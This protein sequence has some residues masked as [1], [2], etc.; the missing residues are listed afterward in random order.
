MS[1]RTRV[2]FDLGSIENLK[3]LIVDD[4]KTALKIAE[5]SFNKNGYF[6]VE[7]ASSGQEC[8]DKVK[9]EQYN[10]IVLDV[11]MEDMNGLDVLQN[12]RKDNNNMKTA[13][14]MA[15]STEDMPIVFD[16]LKKG[17]DEFIIKPITSNSLKNIWANVW[18]RKREQAILTK[19]DKKQQKVENTAKE[20]FSL[21]QK[22]DKLK[23]E[24]D[25]AVETPLK[26]IT[27]TITELL[28]KENNLDP[29]V[30]ETLSKIISTLHSS[31]LYRPVISEIL[32]DNNNNNNNNNNNEG[33]GSYT[34]DEQTKKWL[35]REI[36]Y[37][38]S[39][40][41]EKRRLSI[42][43]NTIL[44]KS[45]Q[46]DPSDES[47]FENIEFVELSEDIKE[48]IRTWD[49][50]VWKHDLDTL[51]SLILFMYE[52]LK[53]IQDFDLSVEQVK[54]FIYKCRTLYH[55][56]PYH[57]FRHAFDV[58]H[59]IYIFLTKSGAANLLYPSDI[60][61][62][63]LCGIG[64]DLDHPGKTNTYLIETYDNLALTYNDTS[65][66]E[67]YHCSKAFELLL[68]NPQTGLLR[69]FEKPQQKNIRSIMIDCILAT[70][71][72]RT[73]ESLSKIKSIVDQYDKENRDHR[74]YL[75]I[76]IMKSADLSNPARNFNISRMWGN[77]I[78]NEFFNQGDCE[79]KIGLEISPF[80]DRNDPNLEQMQMNFIDFLVIPIFTII[81]KIIPV[82]FCLENIINNRSMWEKLKNNT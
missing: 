47:L 52:D 9:E 51:Q 71:L 27:D 40:N 33:R 53:I 63:I 65:V 74:R 24:V 59:S 39:S 28:N 31:D 23:I 25:N 42:S 29:K 15:S 20:L 34:L 18:K 3:V 79:Q 44:T 77:V 4:D 45:Q 19:L 78:Q 81:N 2:S 54:K 70:D 36:G 61:P 82:E 30:K 37:E 49:F 17:A 6:N 8:L 35:S 5:R 1:K 66:L 13:I 7:T 64:H 38:T 10:L 11:Y 75:C 22:L 16:S 26:A 62:L 67:N 41:P 56:N 69:N 68:S 57:N 32:S 72:S 21:E 58:T 55:Q 14:I 76:G 60:L 80:M 12:L 46:L 48:K 73:A 50:N 43:G